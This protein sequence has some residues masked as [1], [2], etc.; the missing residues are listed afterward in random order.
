MDKYCIGCSINRETKSKSSSCDELDSGRTSGGSREDKVSR[1][2]IDSGEGK[3]ASEFLET[4]SEQ[5]IKLD[6]SSYDQNV[7]KKLQQGRFELNVAIIETGIVNDRGKTYGIYAVAITK[8]YDSGYQE[9]WHIYRRYSDFHDLYQKVKEKYYD[10]AKIAFPAKKAFHN[11]DRAVLERRM[12]MLNAWLTQLTKPAI[13]E[14]HMGLQN[15]L[16]SF[17]EQGD[18]DKGV[19]GGIS[20]TVSFN[21]FL[22]FDTIFM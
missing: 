3:D 19:G 17:L 4:S 10:L 7:I 15:L 20:R 13:M 16:L 12:I 5:F 11:M 1:T 18:Y 14:G 8:V 9:K 6:P 21:H 22:S 2:S